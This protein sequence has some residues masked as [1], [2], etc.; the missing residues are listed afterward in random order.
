MFNDC[1][2]FNFEYI[3]SAFDFSF[4]I[5][6]KC[7]KQIIRGHEYVILKNSFLHSYFWISPHIVYEIEKKNSILFY[8]T[9]IENILDMQKKFIHKGT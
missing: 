2:N 8:G 9:C 3:H 7:D 1:L 4:F 6:I 5:D